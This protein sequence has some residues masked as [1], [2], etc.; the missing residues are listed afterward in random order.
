MV[1]T[2]LLATNLLSPLLLCFVLGATAVALRGSLRLPEQA[3]DFLGV[4]LMLAI[5]LHGGRAIAGADISSFLPVA[6]MAIA[7]GMATPLIC[8][9]ILGVASGIPIADRMAIGA[10]YGS[11]S[12]V[13]FAAAMAYAQSIGASPDGWVVALLAIMEAPA[14]L[15]AIVAFKMRS[16]YSLS[17]G[18][19][20][21]EVM[22]GKSVLLLIGG[23]LIGAVSTDQGYARISPFFDGLYYGILCL[24]LLELGSLAASRIKDVRVAGPVLVIFAIAWPLLSGSLAILAGSFLIENPATLA[25]FATLVASASYI[26]AP[27]AIRMAIPEASPGIYLTMSLAITFPLNLVIGIPFYYMMASAING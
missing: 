3:F 5:G 15:V 16:T 25:I 22:G 26:A 27:A 14:I 20:L 19:V 9:A 17:L 6:A 4:Y 10:H 11:V 23:I 12:A 24:F 13:T 18:Q 7:I 2:D 8:S 21:G 1:I